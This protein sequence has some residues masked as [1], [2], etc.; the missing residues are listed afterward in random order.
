MIAVFRHDHCSLQVLFFQG[1]PQM[2]QH[3]TS[4]TIMY[5]HSLYIVD[6]RSRSTIWISSTLYYMN[7][8][9]ALVYE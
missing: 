3:T 5:A 4:S 7:K 6:A 1:I 2:S 9:N 8:L